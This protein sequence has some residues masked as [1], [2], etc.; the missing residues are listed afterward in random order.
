[1]DVLQLRFTDLHNYT[2][3]TS[4]RPRAAVGQLRIS[5]VGEEQV[6]SGFRSYVKHN[7]ERGLVA[8]GAGNIHA[9]NVLEIYDDETMELQLRHETD[10]SSCWCMTWLP[11]DLYST[12]SNDSIVRIW[13]EGAMLQE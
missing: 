12:G 2:E 5:W 13:R 8:S 3:V 11:S 10:T 4:A 6:A 1:M 7:A 9:G